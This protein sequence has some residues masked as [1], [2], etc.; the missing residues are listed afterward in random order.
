MDEPKP[1]PT[2][3]FPRWLKLALAVTLGMLLVEQSFLWLLRTRH[4]AVM[5]WFVSA[6]PT[7]EM[8]SPPSDTPVAA[9]LTT[10]LPSA[11]PSQMPDPRVMSEKNVMDIALLATIPYDRV[12]SIAPDMSRAVGLKY[13]NR[14][15]DAI[16][17]WDLL[18]ETE[19]ARHPVIESQS[20][21]DWSSVPV[22][23]QNDRW[24]AVHDGD[25]QVTILDAQSL[26]IIATLT[27]PDTPLSPSRSVFNL[28]LAFSYDNT[29]LAAG[30]NSESKVY[31]WDTSTWDKAG[32]ISLDPSYVF[33]KIQFNE[34]SQYL[35]VEELRG[36]ILNTQVFQVSSLENI[37]SQKYNCLNMGKHSFILRD[38][39]IN[40]C[41]DRIE[42]IDF[43]S[44]EVICENQ[45]EI[46]VYVTG[47]SS[48]HGLL[49]IQ[50]YSSATGYY[51][52]LINLRTCEIPE[53]MTNKYVATGVGTGSAVFSDS[54]GL[55]FVSPSKYQ[56]VKVH[57]ID[58][59]EELRSLAVDGVYPNGVM[60]L[61]DSG[62]LLLAS[63]ADKKTRVWGIPLTP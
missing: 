10:A 58:T 47:S 7:L 27:I 63:Y 18:A 57:D 45:Y 11:T 43:L 5:S 54:E 36:G 46:P 50:P 20:P 4:E 9:A 19:I 56:H 2:D 25:D 16:V 59:G 35:M 12:L 60:L 32:E 48:Y 28:Q 14:N 3:G 52:I 13:N 1:G 30:I 23:S 61:A 15:L 31:F 51:N 42:T 38:H 21:V 55:F 22:I 53:N 8:Q 44:G 49:F 6:T 34:S 40:T 37:Y 39:L 26:E 17:L 33:S 24:I 29:L 62:R 41:N